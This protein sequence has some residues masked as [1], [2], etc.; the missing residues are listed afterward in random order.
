MKKI[1][2]FR[3]WIIR[4]LGGEIPV[5]TKPMIVERTPP[6]VKLESKVSISYDMLDWYKYMGGEERIKK[7][8]WEAF[9][10]KAS[11]YMVVM[12]HDNPQE[13]VLDCIAKLTIE[14]EL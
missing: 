13:M 12:C 5:P 11:P 8:L 6:S 7:K 4:K 10:E 3:V 9:F 2:K 1:S 14:K